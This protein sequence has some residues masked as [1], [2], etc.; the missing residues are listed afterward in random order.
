VDGARVVCVEVCVDESGVLA[1]MRSSYGYAP[2]GARCVEHAPYRKGR[3]T[4]LI[5]WVRAGKPGGPGGR[6]KVVGVEGSVDRRG[7]EVRALFAWFIRDH[8]A[9]YL[10]PGDVVVWDHHAI[11][12][13]EEVRR[14]IEA[15]G[16]SM[17]AL[18]PRHSATSALERLRQSRRVWRW[19]PTISD[20]GGQNTGCRRSAVRVM[21][22][23]NYI[24][25]VT[26]AGERRPA[27]PYRRSG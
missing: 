6:G 10:R 25:V 14:L 12:R 8:L 19:S 9:P 15:R 1:G 21:V 13:G 17:H 4:S 7:E 26:K 11:H 3:R 20:S 2:G 18:V 24:P 27:K 22:A 23:G 5:G 16:T